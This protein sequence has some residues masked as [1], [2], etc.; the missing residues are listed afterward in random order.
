VRYTTWTGLV[1]DA[2][3]RPANDPYGGVGLPAV[4]A[5]LGFDGLTDDDFVQQEGLPHA[6][7]S[8]MYDLDRL[9]LVQFGFVS[10]G[11]VL[12]PAGRDVADVGLA[13]IWPALAEVH[14]SAREASVLSKLFEASAVEAEGW[15]DF[16]LVDPNEAAPLD[17]PDGDDYAASLTRMTLLGDLERK[18]LI[19]TGLVYGGDPTAVRTTYRAVVLLSEHVDGVPSPLARSSGPPRSAPGSSDLAETMPEGEQTHLPEPGPGRSKGPAYILTRADIEGPYRDLWAQHGHRPSWNEVARVLCL[20]ERTLRRARGR[21]AMN[22][23][24]ITQTPE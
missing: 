5:A 11:N 7:M 13:S 3:A 9:G 8:A 12:T 20:D 15:A 21:L 17:A 23:S 24:P 6:L 18:G 2:L 4:A 1:L 19:G 14:L 22:A 16:L 10:Y